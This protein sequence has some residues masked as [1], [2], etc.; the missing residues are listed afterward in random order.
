MSFLNPIA[1][2]ALAGLAIPISIHLLSRKEGK[3]I[4]MGSIRFLSETA[5]SKFSSLKLNELVLLIIRCVLLSLI[6]LL[7]AGLL[8]PLSPASETQ[9]WAVV[10]KGLEK[11][12]RIKNLLDSLSNNN[13]TLKKLE[14]E[15]PALTE[16][17]SSP[18]PDYYKLTE[19]LAAKENLQALVIA[20]NQLVQ[21][22]GKRN[23]L[24]ENITWLS[25]PVDKIST[26]DSLT[27]N[28]PARDTL[29]I[30]LACDNAFQYDKKIMAAA[31][32]SLYK[33]A[34]QPIIL[35]E[36]TT[37]NFIPT[38]QTDWLI[39]LSD[40]DISFTGK[41]V[42][43]QPNIFHSLLHAES[44]N[45]FVLTSRLDE[46][47]ALE[48][49]L[50]IKLMDM[51]FSDTFTYMTAQQQ[52]MRSISDTLAWSQTIAS[53][54]GTEEKDKP[55]DK[56]LLIIIVALFVIERAFAFYRKQ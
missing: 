12:Q 26:D 23:A 20:K 41:S 47:T 10:E 56:L 25:Y 48:N 39:W 46:K 54:A 40:S 29:V 55:A 2:W 19:E 13:Y 45:T 44:R 30:T 6:V 52:D 15:F 22:K 31:I 36:V 11:D 14:P 51:L 28:N 7:L 3:T 9:Y 33:T 42:R 8:L 32:K 49:H 4:R 21:F 34:P 17:T 18:A 53:I 27:Y 1:L 37:E 5:T 24:P 38:L 50:S 43:F 16:T 35:R